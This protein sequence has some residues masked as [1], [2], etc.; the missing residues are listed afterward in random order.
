MGK[1]YKINQ[2]QTETEIQKDVIDLLK[3]WG[4]TVYRMNAGRKGGIRLH[5]PGTPDLLAQR[6]GH[7]VWIEMK[8]PGEDPSEIQRKKHKELREDGF[9][10]LVIHSVEELLKYKKSTM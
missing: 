7:S 3:A 9:T 1:Y 6:K 10:V 8:K 5:P 4:W 2:T